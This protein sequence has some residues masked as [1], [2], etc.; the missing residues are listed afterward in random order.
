VTARTLIFLVFLVPP[1][2]AHA[3]G[4]FVPGAGP[5]AQARAGAFVARADDPNALLHNPAGI[6]K[7][8]GVQIMLG[9]NAVDYNLSYQRFG[10]YEAPT[11]P[12]DAA[13][14]DGLPYPEVRNQAKPKLGIGDYQLIPNFAVTWDL[15]RPDWPVRI[16]I[17]VIEPQAYPVRKFPELVTVAGV[18]GAPA[19][20]RYDTI[21]QEATFVLPSVGVGYSVL[22]N[23][24]VGVRLT[25]GFARFEASRSV[26]PIV[27]FQET[28]N[29]DSLFEVEK[30]KDSFVPAY[31]FGVLYR[32]IDNL[33][34]GF[35]YN[36]EVKAHATGLGRSTGA[37]LGGTTVTLAPV[38]DTM[39]RC[40]TGGQVDRLKTC[41]DVGL[42]RNAQLGVRYLF[43]DAG[44]D[45]RADVE[46]DLRWENWSKATD[47]TV[48]VDAFD[49]VSGGVLQQ[50]FSRHGFKDTFGVS[51]GGSYAHPIGT[52]KLIVRAGGAFDSA[53]SPDSFTRVDLD[54]KQR[55]TLAGGLA[56]EGSFFRI[57]LGGGVSLEP[58]VT[59]EPCKP[60][61]GPS[62]S[63]IGCA[64][65]GGEIP[66]P[67]RKQPDPIQPKIVEAGQVE[68]PYNAGTYTSG[69]VLFSTGVTLWF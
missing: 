46:L 22:P 32:P 12:A 5:H 1:A 34:L 6:A 64:E 2:S 54:G 8:N 65:G 58:D 16:A 37:M 40:A 42:A 9:W 35:N 62:M 48:L 52:Y 53:A 39:A 57:D 27:N 59:V 45:E 68:S 56:F 14:Y 60:P 38:D 19:P 15:N 29:G 41:I 20:Q 49:N 10:N 26:W 31:G 36:S 17:G 44:G 55:I 3:G 18:D 21:N 67:D 43:R 11:N 33:E 69:Y 47:T 28:K 61:G 23:L 24:D 50:T 66:V 4:P 51:L 30:A 25:W 63:D 7:L 13:P